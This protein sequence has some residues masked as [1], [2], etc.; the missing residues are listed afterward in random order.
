MM[1]ALTASTSDSERERILDSGFD[2]FW[3]KPLSLDDLVQRVAGY[4]PSS[5]LAER[6]K[7]LSADA[8]EGRVVGRVGPAAIRLRDG[9]RSAKTV[10]R[11]AALVAEFVASLPARA[12]AIRAAI[13][14]GDVSRAEELLHQLVGTGGMHGFTPLSQEAARLLQIVKI[15]VIAN[16]PVEL[17]TLE[18]MIAKLQPKSA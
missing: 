14:C 9:V 16:G 13:E 18:D 10:E 6:L 3:S 1:I 15:G 5:I 12:G 7:G 2:D 8:P 11:M 4:L 17:L